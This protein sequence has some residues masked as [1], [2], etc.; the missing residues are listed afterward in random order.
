MKGERID[1]LNLATGEA[2]W[3]EMLVS[4]G[5]DMNLWMYCVM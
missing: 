2:I 1:I 4:R 3:F 5:N